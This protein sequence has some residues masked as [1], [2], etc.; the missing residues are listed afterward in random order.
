MN[1]SRISSRRAIGVALTL[2]LCTGCGIFETRDPEPPG[3]DTT[4]WN[5]PTVP[6]IVFINME[7][8]L[9]DGTGVNYEKSLAD[10]FTFVAMPGDKD[11]LGEGVYQN[12][13]KEVEVG[14]TQQILAAAS[15]I[16]V[17]FLNPEQKVDDD[18]FATFEAPYEFEITDTQ[19]QKTTYKGKAR[20]EMQR[21]SQGWHLIKWEDLE[22][23]EGFATWG[24]L[25]GTTR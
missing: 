22:G 18:P 25:R 16:Q 1:K 5:P 9:E 3:G 2:L 23:V 21:L 19:N 17:S 14:V 10:D 12:W 20:F 8:G 13:T 4:P 24:Y 15:A 11:K 6:S 7:N